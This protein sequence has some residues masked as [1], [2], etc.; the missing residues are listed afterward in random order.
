MA[1]KVG[2]ET[3]S[4]EIRLSIL[5]TFYKGLDDYTI[6]NRGDVGCFVRE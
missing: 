2:I 1:E 3:V 4:S 6:D 5:E